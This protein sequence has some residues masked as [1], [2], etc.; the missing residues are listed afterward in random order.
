MKR[1]WYDTALNPKTNHDPAT[2]G[3]SSSEVQ[4]PCEYSNYWSL[5]L[6]FLREQN[7]SSEV[8]FRF[9]HFGTW[10][11]GQIGV[12]WSLIPLHM[13]ELVRFFSLPLPPGRILSSDLS[14]C[15]PLPPRICPSVQHPTKTISP[16]ICKG[17]GWSSAQDQDAIFHQSLSTSLWSWSS[18]QEDAIL[19]H[20]LSTSI[21]LVQ[22]KR[23][24]VLLLQML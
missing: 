21:T 22:G 24:F 5:F 8:C 13:T 11:Q 9:L 20:G 23:R 3:R 15:I 2:H 17:K 12:V 6:E 19:H 14:A 10:R 7:C 18:V 4:V 1:L 16:D